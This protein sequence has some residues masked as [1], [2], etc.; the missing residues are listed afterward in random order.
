MKKWLIVC[1]L[2]QDEIEKRRF[3]ELCNVTVVANHRNNKKMILEH[4]REG[5]PVLCMGELPEYMEETESPELVYWYMYESPVSQ[6]EKL[7]KMSPKIQLLFFDKLYCNIAIDI[8][9]RKAAYIEPDVNR[10]I[11][12]GR[13]DRRKYPV[14]FIGSYLSPKDGMAGLK[15]NTS[16]YLYP[17]L[18]Q[19]IKMSRQDYG[20]ADAEMWREVLELEQLDYDKEIIDELVL[21]FQQNVVNITNR[22]GTEKAVKALIE[23]EI[24][25][26]VIGQNWE[27]FKETISEEKQ[28]LLKIVDVWEMTGNIVEAMKKAKIVLGV[29]REIREGIS[30]TNQ[31]A[32]NLG[33]KVIMERNSVSQQ[34]EE[35]GAAIVTYSA[36]RTGDCAR[37]IEKL[38]KEKKNTDREDLVFTGGIVEWIKKQ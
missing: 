10:Y 2:R 35:R 19:V 30:M 20:K 3:A 27:I 25:V 11:E 6:C 16:Q 22:F 33:C 24:P 5:D 37:I 18:K 21:A 14:L 32:L 9:Q 13:A 34:L 7:K 1:P 38:L 8:L 36:E 23:K 4:L 31:L 29:N 12:K 17:L 26:A 15:E 28:E